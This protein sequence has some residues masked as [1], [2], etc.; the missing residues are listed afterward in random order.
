MGINQQKRDKYSGKYLMGLDVGVGSLGVALILP[1][2]TGTEAEIIAGTSITF[3]AAADNSDRR[4]NR[5]SR[6]RF[7]RRRSRKTLLREYLTTMLKLDESAFDKTH[8]PHHRIAGC[9]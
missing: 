2:T 1:Q 4:V 7:K 8:I 3:N 6:V 5:G 9:Y